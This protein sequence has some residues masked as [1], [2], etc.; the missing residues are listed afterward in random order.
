MLLFNAA[1]VKVLPATSIVLTPSPPEGV[2][3]VEKTLHSEEQARSVF[4]EDVTS[5]LSQDVNPG[6]IVVLLNKPKKESFMS[7]A[8][9]IGRHKFESIGQY[10]NERSKSIQFTTLKMFK[11][12]EANVVCLFLDKKTDKKQ[13]S[14]LI[15]MEGT[16]ARTLLYVYV[17]DFLIYFIYKMKVPM[18]LKNK[19]VLYSLLLIGVV[20]VLGYI[21]LE[22]YNSMGLIIVLG[23]LSSYF[24]KNMSVNLLVA[25]AGTG[26]MVINNKVQEGFEE[27][28]DNVQKGL[29]PQ[30]VT[31]TPGQHPQ[32]SSSEQSLQDDGTGEKA[33]K[34]MLMKKKNLDYKK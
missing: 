6:D 10:Y 5:L 28:H 19:Y 14:E 3:V 8:R 9:S 31:R 16:R 24:S 26:L 30:N 29:K 20:N 1:S 7:E 4:V 23:V 17:L 27:G 13:A 15:Y 18:L 11:G 21:A 22:D 25:I 12:L 32:G 33:L 2:K 34:M